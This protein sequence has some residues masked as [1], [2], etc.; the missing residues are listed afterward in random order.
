MLGRVEPKVSKRLV[1]MSLQIAPWLSPSNVTVPIITTT[2]ATVP[3]GRSSDGRPAS[4]GRTPT[5]RPRF[6]KIA[7]REKR[8]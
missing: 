4:G 2:T 5:T 1:E 7:R 3:G 6:S 8:L